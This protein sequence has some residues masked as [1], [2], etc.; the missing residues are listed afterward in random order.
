MNDYSINKM[1]EE[2]CATVLLT[3][4]NVVA[5]MCYTLLEFNKIKAILIAGIA[6]YMIIIITC[7]V[8][9]VFL[10]RILP[11][12]EQKKK[13]VTCMLVAGIASTVILVRDS[14]IHVGLVEYGS[15]P[16]IIMLFLMGTF[17]SVLEVFEIELNRQEKST[18]KIATQLLIGVI[19]KTVGRFD[20]QWKTLVISLITAIFIVEGMIKYEQQI[21]IILDMTIVFTIIVTLCAIYSFEKYRVQ[22]KSV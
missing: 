18:A 1:V 20:F 10:W 11:N 13:P 6:E 21:K 17:V 12:C 8:E 22:V 9:R 4:G 2:I 16:Y 15:T 7:Y 14:T 19:I 5:F 3:A